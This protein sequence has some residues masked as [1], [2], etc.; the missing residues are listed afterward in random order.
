MQDGWANN[1]KLDSGPKEKMTK[2]N[3]PCITNFN[4]D[5]APENGLLARI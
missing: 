5:F 1:S 2:R 4:K 3:I